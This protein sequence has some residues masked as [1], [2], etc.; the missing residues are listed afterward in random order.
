MIVSIQTLQ[1]QIGR[2]HYPVAS[3]QQASEMFCAARDKSGLG[4]SR[5]PD[6]FIINDL[7]EKVARI[8][9][10]GRVWPLAEW[11]PDQKPVYD[12]RIGG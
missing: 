4:A 3:F 2:K 10:N 7:G 11:T 1:M 9:Y 8:S 5:V 12:N 6:A